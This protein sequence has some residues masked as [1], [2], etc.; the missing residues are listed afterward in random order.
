[1]VISLSASGSFGVDMSAAAQI[2]VRNGCARRQL[3]AG[4]N[5]RS[6][7]FWQCAAFVVIRFR[8]M[9]CRASVV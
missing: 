2:V 8:S 4:D 9:V 3:L 6:P 5:L 7:T 1:L